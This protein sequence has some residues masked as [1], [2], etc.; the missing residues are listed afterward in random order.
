[1]CPASM[2]L[3]KHEECHHTMIFLQV[4]QFS[5][6]AVHHSL[7]RGRKH[8]KWPPSSPD[9]TP[10]DFFLCCHH[11]RFMSRKINEFYLKCCLM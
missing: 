2:Q 4:H 9:L 8:I 10:L 6:G 1:M 3:L 7:I 5:D 11:Q